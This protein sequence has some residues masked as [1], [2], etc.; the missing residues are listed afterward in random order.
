[1]FTACHKNFLFLKRKEHSLTAFPGDW[2]IRDAH[3]VF[4]AMKPTEFEAAYEP[5]DLNAADFS[6]AL[7]W[8]KEGKRIARKGWNAK[9]QF[10]WLVPEGQYPVRM[11]AIKD[12]FPADV[13]PYG[14]YFALKNAQDVVVPW[15]PSVGDLLATD[16]FVIA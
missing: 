1:M 14:A 9:G 16:W 2:L 7:M 4:H 10:C 12:Y 11:E 5:I 3:N 8:L 13:V 15:V 6:D